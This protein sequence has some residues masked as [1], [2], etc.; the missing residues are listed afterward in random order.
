MTKSKG[1]TEPEMKEK[2]VQEIYRKALKAERDEKVVAYVEKHLD[3]SEV[4]DI[5]LMETGSHVNLMSLHSLHNL[6]EE[7]LGGIINIKRIND[8]K[9]INKFFE[10]SNSRLREGGILIGCVET[11]YNRKQ[12]I[13]RKSPAPFNRVHYAI[14]FVFKRIIPKIR[15]VKKFYFGITG[16]KNRVISKIETYGRLY[17]CG[18]KLVESEN[19]NNV[20]WF[21]AKKIG[22]PD[23]NQHATYGPLIRLKRVGKGGKIFNVYKM[24]TMHP[25]SEY[26]QPYISEKYG[27]QKGGKFDND[28]RITRIGR[29]FRKFW[30]DEMP[31]I[32]NVL[33]GEIKMV[34]VRPISKHYLGLYPEEVQQRRGNYKPGLLPPFYA[35]LPETLEEIVDS[36]VRYMDAHD[37]GK[38]FTDIRYFFKI[39]YNI[40]IKRARSN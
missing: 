28:P 34:G 38:F 9:Y 27:L 11:T 12:R 40:L 30:I 18:F 20:L 4:L 5:A 6:I 22:E 2:K 35:D 14:D 17:S 15:F 36:E 16:G 3:L 32:I 21:V 10:A 39:L 29:F 7:G 26:L 25:Y 23:F 33:K 24:R 31:M 8:I 1:F 37:K 19:I 13:L